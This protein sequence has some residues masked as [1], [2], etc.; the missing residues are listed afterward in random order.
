MFYELPSELS[1][2]LI[3]GV[4]QDL[5]DVRSDV[6]RGLASSG[7]LKDIVNELSKPD[8]YRAIGPK[9]V[10]TNLYR[11]P[12]GWYLGHARGPN[13]RIIGHAR[14][15]KISGTGS[16]LLT[17]AGML[18]GQLMLVEMSQKLDKLQ[19]SVDAVR[20]ALDDDRAE[21]LRAAIH[22]AQSA[23]EAAQDGNRRALVLATIPPL[24]EAVFQMIATLKREIEEVPEPSDWKIGGVG[25]GF[26]REPDMR[27]KL[28]KA[29]RTAHGC[30]A[31]SFALGQAYVAVGELKLADRVVLDCL[32]QL[33]QA[34]LDKAELRGRLIRPT[35]VD[36]RPELFWSKLREQLPTL[37]ERIDAQSHRAE[38]DPI[39]I[40]IS[41]KPQQLLQFAGAS[42]A[43]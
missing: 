20:A 32:H 13:G 10:V 24:R 33:Q 22:G 3:P 26:D 25:V 23:L 35:E 2:S 5:E 41:V 38:D 4:R 16:R 21:K 40:E 8:A 27:Q 14:W 1:K 28:S 12:D 29:Q 9:D 17:S 31:G 18:T 30:L 36:D 19:G 42:K 43:N 11:G 39:E 37:C 6:V 34:A 15:S 7:A